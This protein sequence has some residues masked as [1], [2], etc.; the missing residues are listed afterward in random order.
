[1]DETRKQNGEFVQNR[2][3]RQNKCEVYTQNL[4]HVLT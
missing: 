2:G 4:L 3:Y 1:M